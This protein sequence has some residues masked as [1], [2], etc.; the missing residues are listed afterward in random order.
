MRRAKSSRA[1]ELARHRAIFTYARAHNLTLIEAE[2][3]MA[4]ERWEAAQERLRAVTMCGRRA[5]KTAATEAAMQAAAD[6]GF[7]AHDLRRRAI[8]DD[9]PWMMRD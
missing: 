2:A 4:H 8:P 3:A 6:A 1:D 7:R 9:A 5:G